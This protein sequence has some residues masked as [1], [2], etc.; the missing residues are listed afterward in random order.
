MKASVALRSSLCLAVSVL[1]QEFDIASYAAK[2]VITRDVAIIGGGATGT[3]AA[4]NLRDAGKSVVVVERKGELG[5][6]TATYH[7]P[8]TGK[9]VNYGLQVNYD[10]P[11]ARQFF[12]RLNITV[13][14][15][16]FGGGD[17]LY[18]D[19]RDGSVVKNYTIPPVH[20]DYIRELHKYPY[21][22]DGLHLPDPVPEDLLLPWSEYLKKFNLTDDAYSTYSRPAVAGDLTKI[23]AL[24]VF[25]NLNTAMIQEQHGATIVNADGDNAEI[26]RNALRELGSD[27]LLNSTVAHGQ[28]GTTASAGVRLN[29]TTPHGHKLIVAKQLVLALPPVLANLNVFGL[30]ARESGVWSQF[31]G[32]DFYT[33]VVENTGLPANRSYANRG[34]D[35]DSHVAAL[36]GTLMFNPSPVEGIFYYWYSALHPMTQ[37]QVEAATRDTLKRLQRAVPGA[38]PA[39]PR[40]VAYDSHA[41]LHPTAD[42]DAIRKGV[43]RDMYGL[44]GYRNTWYTGSLTVTG[45][46]QLWNNTAQL[47][48][49]I[50]KAAK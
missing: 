46:P 32:G 27:V 42:A 21:V 47:L 28:R 24:Y 26:Y 10:M 39:E 35:T 48:P 30:D 33:G 2:D 1:A 40:F 5:G 50:I 38:E 13:K 16:E 19:F 6:H 20:E 17:T 7:D 43:Y 44:Q 29:V 22:E 4:I 14:K 9:P 49:G 31:A 11:L 37:A 25:N 3:Y 18:L 45:S 41:P 8:K 23:L 34:R 36:P 12:K 15:A